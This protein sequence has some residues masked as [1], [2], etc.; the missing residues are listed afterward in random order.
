MTIPAHALTIHKSC[1]HT[2]VCTEL[3]NDTAAT[4]MELLGGGGQAVNG[5]PLP[6]IPN[7]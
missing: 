6:S 3:Y 2:E 5:D 1:Y 4:Q 7:C